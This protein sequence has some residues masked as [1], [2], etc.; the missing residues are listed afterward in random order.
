MPSKSAKSLCASSHLATILA[1]A[2]NAGMSFPAVFAWAW[3]PTRRQ[4]RL[5]GSALG[6]RK[7]IGLNVSF[8]RRAASLAGFFDLSHTF[9]GPLR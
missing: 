7:L 6:L 4:S 2:R 1:S 9:D 5:P 8:G 3:T